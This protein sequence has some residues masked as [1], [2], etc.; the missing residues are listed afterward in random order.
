MGAPARTVASHA[1]F[2]GVGSSAWC[3]T[4]IGCARCRVGLYDEKFLQWPSNIFRVMLGS[5][6]VLLAHGLVTVI[7]HHASFT[8][9][10]SSLSLGFAF[11]YSYTHWPAIIPHS[12]R[13]PLLNAHSMS[14]LHLPSIF[15]YSPCPPFTLRI[16]VLSMR[17]S[18]VSIP[19]PLPQTRH[20]HFR[21]SPFTFTTSSS[22]CIVHTV[23]LPRH[24]FLITCLP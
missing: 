22:A 3:C 5:L 24:M 2:L 12:V 7:H 17:L 15:P 21:Q 18:Q 10:S 8:S 4:H 19:A 13:Y 9:R 11:S 23:P 1:P 16:L 14:R 6:V 20:C